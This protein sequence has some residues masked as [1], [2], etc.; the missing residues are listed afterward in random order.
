MI[1]TTTTLT[2]SE[3][4][5]D[6]L[7]SIRCRVRYESVDRLGKHLGRRVMEKKSGRVRAFSRATNSISSDSLSRPLVHAYES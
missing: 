3:K 5:G 6:V 4:V 7:L 2:I 1:G